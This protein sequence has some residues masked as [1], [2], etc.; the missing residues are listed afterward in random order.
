MKGYDSHFIVQNV[1][2]YKEKIDIIPNNTEKYMSI[3][4]GNS[5]NKQVY[6][7]FIDSLQFMCESLE[8][9]VK[10]IKKFCHLETDIENDN[11]N[12]LK[13]KGI[14]PYDYMDSWDK[15]MKQC[16]HQNLH[17]LAN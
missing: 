17:F 10:N 15:L 4:I 5:R 13:Q 9:L 6:L 12:L 8:N 7:R 16:Y 11:L 3:T 1:G 14:Y 2:K